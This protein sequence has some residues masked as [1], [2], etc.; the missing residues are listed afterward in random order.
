MLITVRC[1][2]NKVIAQCYEEFTEIRRKMLQEV[3]KDHPA[4]I[5]P[6]MMNLNEAL[7]PLL[8]KVL[9]EMNMTRPC[10]RQKFLTSSEYIEYYGK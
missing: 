10:C 6:E 4:K 5:L 8:G 2:C 9:D 3:L 1:T 7:Q